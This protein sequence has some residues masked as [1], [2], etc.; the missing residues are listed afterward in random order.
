VQLHNFKKY[1]R[2]SKIS[3]RRYAESHFEITKEM[4]YELRQ[5]DYFDQWKKITNNNLSHIQL[6]DLSFFTF[7]IINNKPSYGYYPCPLEI[8]SFK[9]FLIS[10]EL[11]ATKKNLTENIEKYDL[12]IETASLRTHV[13]PIRYDFDSKSYIAGLHPV[14]HLHIGFDNEIRIATRREF[15][16]VT[17]ILFIIRQIYPENWSELLRHAGE[18]KI[19]NNIRSDLALLPDLHWNANDDLQNYIF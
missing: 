4:I 11:E 15:T 19:E 8:G 6:A 18:M 10:N 16:P 13:T 1:F 12:A 7:S 5:L 17:F 3:V 9:D 14:A 2:Y